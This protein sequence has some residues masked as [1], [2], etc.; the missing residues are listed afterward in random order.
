MKIVNKIVYWKGAVNLSQKISDP[1]NDSLLNKSC[2][3]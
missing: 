1:V 2:V 3:D